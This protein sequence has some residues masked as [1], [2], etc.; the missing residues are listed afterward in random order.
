MNSEKVKQRTQG[1]SERDLLGLENRYIDEL[2]YLM[3][4][5]CFVVIHNTFFF[6]DSGVVYNYVN[7]IN[8]IRI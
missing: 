3:N 1:S 8:C 4:V 2:E 7:C 5:G 6:S